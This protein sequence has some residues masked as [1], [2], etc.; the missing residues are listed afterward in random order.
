MLLYMSEPLSAVTLREVVGDPEELRG[1]QAVMESD[2]GFALRVTGHPRGPAD[3]HSTLLSSDDYGS[4]VELDGA[5]HVLW[6]VQVWAAGRLPGT[7][8]MVSQAKRR[9]LPSGSSLIR[10]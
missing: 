7:T 5:G 10:M 9:M 1:L 2:E 4:S 8:W 3:A 6:R